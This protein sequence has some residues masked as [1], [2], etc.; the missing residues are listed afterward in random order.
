MDAEALFFELA[1]ADLRRAADLFLPVHE[2]SH[3][4][5]SHVSLEVSPLLAYGTQRSL[6]QARELHAQ[7]ARR[8]SSRRGMN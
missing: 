8:P 1:I 4:V 6:A 2:R 7:A 5:D 3:G